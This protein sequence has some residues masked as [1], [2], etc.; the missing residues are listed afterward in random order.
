MIMI[1]VQFTV[2]AGDDC[3]EVK[4]TGMMTSIMMITVVMTIVMMSVTTSNNEHY[5]EHYNIPGHNNQHMSEGV[6][7]GENENQRA[8]LD[9]NHSSQYYETIDNNR[10]GNTESQ[11]VAYSSKH[12]DNRFK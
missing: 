4:R 9:K 6:Y 3:T 8:Y 10:L 7:H 5:N 12:I 11:N 1:K 2:N